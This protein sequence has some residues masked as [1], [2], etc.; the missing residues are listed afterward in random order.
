MVAIAKSNGIDSTNTV[1]M[2]YVVAWSTRHGMRTFRFRYQSVCIFNAL[3][4][5][6]ST[7]WCLRHGVAVSGVGWVV[8]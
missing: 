6:R 4:G 7:E 3:L 8:Q 5:L 2:H 1:F